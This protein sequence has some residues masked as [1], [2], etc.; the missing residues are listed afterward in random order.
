LLPVLLLLLGGLSTMVRT[1]LPTL[2]ALKLL[3]GRWLVGGA[4]SSDLW[5]AALLLPPALCFLF[6][7]SSL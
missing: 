1:S 4:I 2:V 3:G 7:Y 6:S 5:L